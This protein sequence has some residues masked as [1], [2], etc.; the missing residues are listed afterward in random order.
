MATMAGL[1]LSFSTLATNRYAY[2]QS[3]G[4]PNDGMVSSARYLI[5]Y[6]QPFSN[7]T[8][9]K[10][11]IES[12]GFSGKEPKVSNNSL[13]VSAVCLSALSQEN[14]NARNAIP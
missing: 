8:V 9:Y 11:S 3:C 7:G 10:V 5:L 14:N 6:L 1:F 4:T 13:S 2:T 12:S